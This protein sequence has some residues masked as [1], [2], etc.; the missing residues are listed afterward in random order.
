MEATLYLP[1]YDYNDGAFDVSNDYYK[2]DEYAKAMASEYNMNKDVVFNSILES[3][4]DSRSLL[5]GSDG[6]LYKLGS[7][8]SQGI[9]KVAYSSCKCVLYNTDGKDE[10]VDGLITHFAR[11][12]PFVEMIE[13]DV[14]T[15]EEEF[16]SE[17]ALWKREH[18]GINKYKEYKGEEWSW[19]NEPK[20]DIRMHFKNNGNEDLYSV[21]EN[22]KI[23]D[24]MEDGSI[25]IFVERLRIIDKFF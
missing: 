9:E 6:N 23:M 2:G 16:E 18:S 24:I 8:T 15:S 21:L 13:F 22:C 3:K 1:Y 5:Q 12:E 20:R 14:D 19:M 4:N 17:I 7:T 11:Q 25:V 10:T